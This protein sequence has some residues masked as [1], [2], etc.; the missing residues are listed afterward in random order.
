MQEARIEAYVHFFSVDFAMC[1]RAIFGYKC[2]ASHVVM[3]TSS[4]GFKPDQVSVCLI[5]LRKY[6]NGGGVNSWP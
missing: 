2:G 4:L 3:W 5:G 6:R 1:N